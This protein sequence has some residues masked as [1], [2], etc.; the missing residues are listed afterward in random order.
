MLYFARTIKRSVSFL[1]KLLLFFFAVLIIASPSFAA[2]Q[3]LNQ[4]VNKD[5]VKIGEDV[6]VP[7]NTIVKSA[8]AINGNVIVEGL[9]QKDAVAVGGNVILKSKAK[10]IGDVVS[11]GGKIKQEPGATIV[12]KETAISLGKFGALPSFITTKN[13]VL[14]GAFISLMSIFAMIALAL[15]IVAFFPHNIGRISYY[16]E[17]APWSSFF[18]GLLMLLLVVP[19]IILLVVSIFGIVFIPVY[20]IVFI[21][22]ACFGLVAVSQLIGKKVFQALK[23]YNKPMMLEVLV[24]VLIIA[25]VN[26]IPVLGGLVKAIVVT[27][28]L[29]AVWTTRM[30]TRN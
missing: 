19:I 15:L 29:G 25:L 18:W 21:A 24:G 11:I 5:M 10:V 3:G 14:A 20:L 26:L 22:A 23:V 2:L 13:M 28:G 27:I 6:V 8:V 9:V 17:R 12:G 7:N 4:D 1:K 30:G 16:S